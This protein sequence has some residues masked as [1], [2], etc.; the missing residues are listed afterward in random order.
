[1]AAVSLG[2]VNLD[3]GGIVSQLMA[4]ERRPLDD[5]VTKNTEYKSQL[6]ELGRLK[7]ALSSFQTTMQGLSSL[8]KF[9]TY[10]SAISESDLT[11]KFTA[12]VNSDA[13]AGIYAI[14]V[15]NLAEGNKWGS[16]PLNPGFADQ[17][18]TTFTTSDLTID[19]GTNNLTIPDI[20]GMTLLEVRDA[21]NTAANADDVGVSASIITENSSSYRLVV[22]AAE[23]G[24]A[25][26]I[27]MTSTG[28]ALTQLDLSETET[29]LDA[30]VKIDGYTVTG[31]TNTITDA[32]SGVTLDLLTA[33]DTATESGKTSTLTVSRDTAAVTESVNQLVSSYNE[34]QSSIKVYKSG[35]LSGDSSLNT[36]QNMMRNV[37][38]TSAGLSSAYNYLSEV[39]ITTDSVT[40][41]LELDST[42]LDK[43]ITNDY[44]AVSQLFATEDSGVAFRMEALMDGFLK[45]DGVIKSREDG[46]NARIDNNEDR[47][48]NLEY[49]ME[50]IEARY[51][52]Q[53]SS[54]DSLIGQMNSTS[55][56]LTQSLSSLPGFSSGK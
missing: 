24:L 37:L 6:S 46:I 17:D 53:F 16:N 35:A 38:N 47:Q 18:T 49:R 50:K 54:L 30:T 43:A 34:L 44:E 56:S 51:L 52:K 55:S 36:I 15:K 33:Q 45:Y 39:G 12:S 10:K 8:D 2:G 9:E 29:A 26:A 21:I 20:S 48:I 27:S 41:E 19:D 7:G 31:S 32:I 4:L 22:T 42:I 23:T 14:E 25:N 13:T 5:L 28:D 3:V 40:G 11:Q 1:M